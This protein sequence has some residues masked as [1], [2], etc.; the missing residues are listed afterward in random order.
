MLYLE[1][2]E[3]VETDDKG[4]PILQDEF[5]LTF[6]TLSNKKAQGI[7]E[8]STELL[9]NADTLTRSRLFKIIKESYESGIESEIPEDFIKRKSITIPKTGNASECVNYRTITLLS[10]ASKILLNILKNKSDPR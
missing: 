7:D 3:D 6:R 8:I 9:K 1:R 10:Q 5:E 2:E 4:S